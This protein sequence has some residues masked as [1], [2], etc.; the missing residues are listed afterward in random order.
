[1]PIVIDDVTAPEIVELVREHLADMSAV[2]PPGSR[3]ALDLEG[4]APTRARGRVP[5]ARR[6]LTDVASPRRNRVRPRLSPAEPGNRACPT[7]L[8]KGH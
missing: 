3:H 8:A 2:S 4:L 5:A 6:R 1:M 7:E